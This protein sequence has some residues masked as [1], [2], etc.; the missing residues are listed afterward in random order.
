MSLDYVNMMLAL[1]LEKMTLE[2]YS[3]LLMVN[4]QDGAEKSEAYTYVW[5][6]QTD[7]D[8]YGEWNFEVW[9]QLHMEDFMKMTM[10]FVEELELPDSKTRVATYESFYQQSDN[11]PTIP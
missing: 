11:G 4:L 3:R 8:L 2:F 7:P 5:A 6:N 9:K 1:S 10:N